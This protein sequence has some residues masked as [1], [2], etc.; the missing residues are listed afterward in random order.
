MAGWREGFVAWKWLSGTFV[1]KP[2]AFRH[3]SCLEEGTGTGSGYTESCHRSII[4]PCLKRYLKRRMAEG[5]SWYKMDLGF[6]MINNI[7][8]ALVNN[9]F[10]QNSRGNLAHWAAALI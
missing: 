2:M 9:Q 4:F 7:P 5:Y 1:A 3:G 10:W 6:E 8:G